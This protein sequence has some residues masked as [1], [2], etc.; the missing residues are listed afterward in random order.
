[1]RC[2]CNLVVLPA[3]RITSYGMDRWRQNAIA[4]DLQVDTVCQLRAD[5]LAC[6]PTEVQVTT[7]VVTARPCRE[8]CGQWP[9][10]RFQFCK[11]TAI[12]WVDVD[13]DRGIGH[14]GADHGVRPPTPPGFDLVRVGGG[15]NA[16]GTYSSGGRFL[17]HITTDHLTEIKIGACIQTMLLHNDEGAAAEDRVIRDVPNPDGVEPWGRTPP[18]GLSEEGPSDRVLLWV[19][20]LYRLGLAIDYNPT[21]AVEENLKVPRS[22][23]GRWI[24][25]ARERGYL[26]PA[27]GQGRAGG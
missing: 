12:T 24:A 27:E 5:Q 22:T 18:E 17:G 11:I 20:H 16:D 14:S 26:E 21:K 4:V 13:H 23:A 1:M 19:A 2:C 7:T 10:K 6:R 9:S 3:V 8:C 15:V 25:R